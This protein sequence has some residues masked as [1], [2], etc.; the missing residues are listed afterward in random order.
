MTNE[1]IFNATIRHMEGYLKAS[2]AN[3]NLC[4]ETA[5]ELIQNFK[6]CALAAYSL[7]SYLIGGSDEAN[8]PFYQNKLDNAYMDI[9][10]PAFNKVLQEVKEK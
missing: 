2:Q 5:L 9:Y 7:G 10:K 4:K 6:S 1:Q 3:A 8:A